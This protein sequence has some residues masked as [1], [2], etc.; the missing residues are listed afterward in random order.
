M[1]R[2][3]EVGEVAEADVVSD[4]GDRSGVVGEEARG[5]AET[6]THEVLVWRDAEHVS[7]EP[8]EVKGAEA[9]FLGRAFE[10]DRLVAV[11]G[12]KKGTDLFS[13]F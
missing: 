11:L 3:D 12:T 4:V 5:V 2:A 13:G 9:G 6:R 8:Q 7:E 10:I 1:K